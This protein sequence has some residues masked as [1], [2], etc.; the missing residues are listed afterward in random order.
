MSGLP[1]LTCET[2]AASEL[3][4]I[5]GCGKECAYVPD[6]RYLDWPVTD[7]GGRDEATVR[8][9][10]LRPRQVRPLITLGLTG[11]SFGI[12]SP[13]RRTCI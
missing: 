5:L 7:P 10:Y 13:R 9:D 4:I 11:F 12:A 8:A 1:Q 6:E 2:V 3:A